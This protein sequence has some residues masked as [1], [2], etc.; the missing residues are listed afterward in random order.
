MDG[1]ANLAHFVMQN[2]GNSPSMDLLK[3]YMDVKLH[4]EYFN[5]AC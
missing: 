5:R 1:K 2:F 3:I 4:D